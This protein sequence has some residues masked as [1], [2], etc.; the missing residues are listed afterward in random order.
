VVRLVADTH[1]LVW[2]LSAPRKLGAA[3]RRAFAAADEG[4]WLCCV[5]AIALVEIALL[6]ER[7][8]LAIGVDDVLRAL[9]G[10]PGYA[11][12]AL[13]ADQAVEFA[14]L[15]GVK[16]PMDRLVLAA[17][18]ATGSRLLSSDDVLDGFGVDRVWD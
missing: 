14:A 10:H 3:A 9:A 13:D 2:H 5:P 18:R 8:R 15:V 6:E 16:D 1:A 7:D 11:V 12:L 17:A 4:R